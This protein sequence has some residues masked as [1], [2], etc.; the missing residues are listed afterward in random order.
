MADAQPPAGWYP[1]PQDAQQ[2]RYWD[3][4][5]WTGHTAPSGAP[6]SAPTGDAPA[7]G[8]PVPAGPP[9]WQMPAGDPTAG[10]KR[11]WFKRKVFW[12]PVTIV[13]VLI[14][15]GAIVGTGSN[16]SNALEKAIKNDG[17]QQLQ[18][19]ASQQFPGATVDITNVHCVEQGSS[20]TYDCLVDFTLSDASTGQSQSYFQDV[21]GSCDSNDQ[22]LWHTTGAPQLKAGTSTS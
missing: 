15:I 1:D 14:I 9:S 7:Y 21:N 5:T 20:Q 13:V 19:A 2:Q 11:P 18:A 8:A 17:Q 16:H 4:S 12:I 10:A 6:P 3:G 22:C